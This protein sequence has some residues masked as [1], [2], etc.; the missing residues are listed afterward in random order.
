M[1]GVPGGV[2]Y[3]S[4][5]L[6]AGTEMASSGTVVFQDGVNA[7]KVSFGLHNN[8]LTAAVNMAV[9]AGTQSLMLASLV[10]NDGGGVSFGLSNST[11]TASV[12]SGLTNVNISAGTT[13]Q[14]LSNLVFANGSGVT[15][16]LSG[17]TL[18]ASVNATASANINVSAGTTSNNLSNFVFANGNGVSFGLSGSTVTASVAASLTAIN[19][20][21][22][23][24][25]QNL[26][27]FV[28]AN[29]NGVTFGLSGSTMTASVAA[30]LTN[31]VFSAGTSSA[32]LSAVEFDNANGVSFGLNGAS[33]TA[34]IMTANYYEN[35]GA[36][37]LSN[38]GIT[39]Y[40]FTGSHRSLIVNPLD[41]IDRNFP[42]N[43]NASTMM[44]QMSLSGSTATMSQVF[45]SKF[46]WGVYTAN[47]NT[48]SLLNSGSVSFGFNAANTNN[49]TAQAGIR[50]LTVHSS[51]W[52]SSP[53][54]VAGS[55]YYFAW[56]W[57]SAG[58]LNQTGSLFGNRIYDTHQHSGTI[59]VNPSTATSMGYNGLW[60]GVYTATTSALPTAIQSNELN[61][62]DGNAGFIPHLKFIQ[63][64]GSTIF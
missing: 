64:T 44:W 63:H 41:G 18:T 15:F 55:E 59:G 19:I 25:S 31:V 29:G 22:G 34:Q 60:M 38:T 14:N 51:L 43:I 10:F 11:I 23:T 7:G 54:F 16:G 50:F 21:G 48:L 39:A 42:V 37:G 58:V 26:T 62:I 6:S 1:N 30:G 8:I 35:A 20:S 2:Y 36:F 45:T 56:F 52:S 47:K 12:A 40:V 53:Q 32:A 27:N 4:L 13:S 28:F 5:A 49:S 9:S 24:T 57:S 61:K 33:V 17:S 46:F 3:P